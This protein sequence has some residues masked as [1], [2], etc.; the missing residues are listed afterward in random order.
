MDEDYL[1]FAK[2]VEA[3]SLSAAGRL[4]SVSPAMVSKRLA[5][6]ERRLGVRLLHRTTRKIALTEV[7]E[8]FH[9]DVIAILHAIRVAENR[10]TGVR[11]EPSGLLRVSAPTSFGR[12]HIAPYLHSFLSAYPR[13]EL[14]LDLTD[15]MVDLVSDRIDLAVRITADIP[16]SLQGHRLSD[17]R[18]RPLRWTKAD[19][20][21]QFLCVTKMALRDWGLFRAYP[22][23][24]K[25][26]CPAATKARRANPRKMG[27]NFAFL[28]KSRI[29]FYG[30]GRM[31]RP[32]RFELLSR[33]STRRGNAS[34]KP[35]LASIR[36]KHFAPLR[37]RRRDDRS[38]LI[39]PRAFQV[40]SRGV[41]R[42]RPL[43]TANH[44]RG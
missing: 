32:E 27:R 15:A 1:L 4:M 37:W 20:F 2:V 36:R 24:Q 25:R 18:R 23:G 19:S 22:V 7:G 44:R 28:R 5:R 16:S 34:L 38:K 29:G 40:S 6:L 10:A 8:R 26:L 39:A 35:S 14:E 31:A 42:C 13:V 21:S 3:G 43:Q 12:L 17:S 41:D 33:R 9:A 30:V 11:D